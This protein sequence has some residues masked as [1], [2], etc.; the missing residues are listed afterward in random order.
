ML[1]F[2][3]HWWREE[4]LMEAPTNDKELLEA[5][6]EHAEYRST[7]LIHGTAAAEAQAQVAAWLKQLLAQKYPEP[8]ST[9]DNVTSLDDHRIRAEKEFEDE[10]VAYLEVLWGKKTYSFNAAVRDLELMRRGQDDGSLRPPE[11]SWEAEHVV[12]HV[13]SLAN[14]LARFWNQDHLVR[15]ED[16]RPETPKPTEDPA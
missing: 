12:F 4:E 14:D 13:R 5:A 7:I 15:E 8:L 3:V 11:T 9:E 16:D 1:N 10:Q 6:I 2:P